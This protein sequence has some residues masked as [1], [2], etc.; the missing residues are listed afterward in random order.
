MNN[1]N[2]IDISNNPIQH[3]RTKYIDIWHY[4][5]QELVEDKIIYLEYVKTENQLIDILTKPLDV[6]MFQYFRGAIGMCEIA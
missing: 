1:V 5:I 3:L 6:K 4:F 2:A